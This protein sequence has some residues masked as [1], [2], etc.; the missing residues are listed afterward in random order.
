[1]VLSI[2]GID[3]SKRTFNVALLL[4]SKEKSKKFSND[5]AGFTQLR[6]WLKEWAPAGVHACMEAT[7]RY[8]ELLAEFLYSAGHCVSVVNPARIKGYAQAE[9]KRSKTDELDAG[10]IARFCQ[11]Q[12]PRAWK[13]LDKEVRELQEAGR[14]LDALKGMKY[15][16]SNRLDSGLVCDAV[17]K[18]IEKHIEQM[19]SEIAEME[20]WLK[21]KR[22]RKY[23][24]PSVLISGRNKY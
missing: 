3:V 16:E 19:D 8:Y 6:D 2:L 5:T 18:A 11:K 15:Q 17:K 4:E 21:G 7:G 12:N 23:I 9:L 10:L 14:Y 20:K 22:S 24:Y 13:P 1:M